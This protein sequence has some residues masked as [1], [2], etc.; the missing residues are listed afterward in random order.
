MENGSPKNKRHNLSK[1][2]QLNYESFER[3]VDIRRK[4]LQ[5]LN[6]KIDFSLSNMNNLLSKINNVKNLV[7]FK[8]YDIKDLK[9]VRNL[10][11]S[12]LI[13]SK[14]IKQEVKNSSNLLYAYNLCSLDLDNFMKELA[15]PKKSEKNYENV[16]NFNQNEYNR[17]KKEFDLASGGKT[18]HDK[19]FISYFLKN[20]RKMRD[21]YNLKLDLFFRE[22]KKKISQNYI[23]EIVKKVPM[24]IREKDKRMNKQYSDIKS[25]Y[26]D[27]YKISKSFE[28]EEGLKD[29]EI[30]KEEE[31]KNEE[32]FITKNSK[33]LNQKKNYP[34]YNKD[35]LTYNQNNYIEEIINENDKEENKIN[36]IK[37]EAK[38]LHK[39]T[40]SDNKNFDNDNVNNT[41]NNNNVKNIIN[42][43]KKRKPFSARIIKTN[44]FNATIPA[45]I[46][47]LSAKNNNIKNKQSIRLKENRVNSSIINQRKNYDT[48]NSNY[49]RVFINNYSYKNNNKLN[50]S[51]SP[52]I[53]SKQTL[54]SSISS[55]RP[56][57]AFSSFNN[58]NNNTICHLNN[59]NKLKLNL[60][61]NSSVSKYKKNTD[62]DKYINELNKI[63]K[64]SNYTTNKFKKS[65]KELGKKKL[66]QKSNSQIFERT[67]FVDIQKIKKNLKLDRNPHSFINDRKLIIDNSRKVKLMLIEKHKEILNGIVLELLANQKRVHNFYSDYSHY[68]K[69]LLKFK[70]NKKFNKLA[71]E[72]MV[73]E[74]KLDK[75]KIY[76]IFEQDEDKIMDYLKEINNKHRFDDDEWKHILHKHKNLTQMDKAKRKNIFLNGNLH[77]KHL[78]SKY[79]KNKD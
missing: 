19:I 67:N 27:M 75:E 20:E 23:Y 24:C 54:Y 74:K 33:I 48:N 79:K 38:P 55:T 9:S 37:K 22:Q 60:N 43:R 58:N 15:K 31:N 46:A 57:S 10:D 3:N 50:R 17:L 76:E 41:T 30:I 70:R 11:N 64:Y 26:Y 34:K 72:T 49:N 68:E 69:M 13:Y 39:T 61:Q 53:T 12:A 7:V 4:N 56:I 28:L 45:S 59:S 42:I 62:F 5:I 1:S 44:S 77:K 29:I 47:S 40:S 2:K 6:S 14:H 66:F 18:K 51:I 16:I 21:L 73:L 63:I 25:K 78:V 71:N 35:Y 52:N 65:S 36:Y 32:L 8:K